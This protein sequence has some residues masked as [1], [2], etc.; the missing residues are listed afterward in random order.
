MQQAM[1][2]AMS[3]A[4]NGGAR[5]YYHHDRTAQGHGARAVRVEARKA[6]GV[7]GVLGMWTLGTGSARTQQAQGAEASCKPPG[8]RNPYP[9]N[10]AEMPT[11][12]GDCDGLPSSYALTFEHHPRGTV[13]LHCH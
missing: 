8:G 9:R 12:A 11:S 6:V 7:A 10:T 5:H 4:A 3:T 13:T 1:A 2:C